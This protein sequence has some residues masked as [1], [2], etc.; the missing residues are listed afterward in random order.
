MKAALEEELSFQNGVNTALV[1]SILDHIVVK[2]NSRKETLHLEIHL[3]FGS[4]YSG[5]L[6]REKDRRDAGGQD[7]RAPRQ[8]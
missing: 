7:N 4:P 6:E 5:I 1:A 3:K 2:K 8:G